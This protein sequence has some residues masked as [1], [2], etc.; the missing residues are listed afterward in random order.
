MQASFA[1][2]PAYAPGGN[3]VQLPGF[4]AELRD[5]VPRAD[6]Q[7]GVR[8]P[9]YYGPD[10]VRE[11]RARRLRVQTDLIYQFAR[12]VAGYTGA[13]L[14]QYWRGGEASAHN[15][16]VDIL[17]ANVLANF[18]PSGK[19][20]PVRD[21]EAEKKR[22]DDERK[23]A[24][25][26]ADAGAVR[27]HLLR[28]IDSGTTGREGSLRMPAV[29]RELQRVV[30]ESDA[31]QQASGATPFLPRAGSTPL[32]TAPPPPV[33]PPPLTPASS[34]PA[35]GRPQ[36]RVTVSQ[37]PTYRATAQSDEAAGKRGID[38]SGNIVYG[39]DDK[40]V[41]LLRLMLRGANK[42]QLDAWRMLY[43]PETLYGSGGTTTAAK[44]RAQ[45]LRDMETIHRMLHAG[46]GELGWVQAPQHTGVIFFSDNFGAGVAAAVADVRGLA[47]KPWATE[48]ALMTHEGVRDLFAQ[49]T[50]MH[51]NA[52]R[53]RSA[54]RWGGT[55][56]AL[57]EHRRRHGLLINAFRRLDRTADGFLTVP[58]ADPWS[59][60]AGG[61]EQRRAEEQRELATMARTGRYR[62]DVY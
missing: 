10:W 39:V 24:F 46:E 2:E 36:S 6:G 45:Y 57:A 44:D 14:D 58:R 9:T 49:L 23:R 41:M 33:G 25:D 38:E 54:A 20:L 8:D 61:R 53:Q 37:P 48:L 59:R 4:P 50:A 26:T 43:E 62:S 47:G 34:A 18:S 22:I 56:Q 35:V 12:M 11:E 19:P 60:D 42:T 27:E 21:I 31:R 30:A 5:V 40:Y 16:I 7:P 3:Y 32:Q 55:Q 28:T 13:R 17:V 51:M 15:E 52:A 29:Q 1:D